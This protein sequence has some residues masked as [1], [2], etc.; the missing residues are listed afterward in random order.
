MTDEQ[1]N[2]IAIRL[3]EYGTS[4][5]K[6]CIRYYM[7]RLNGRLV[8]SDMKFFIDNEIKIGQI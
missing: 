7:E 8:S 1:Y 2:Q 5:Q 3:L 4:F 6:K